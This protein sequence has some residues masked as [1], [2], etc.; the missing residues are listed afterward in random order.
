MIPLSSAYRGALVSSG[1]FQSDSLTIGVFS[2]FL[3]AQMKNPLVFWSCGKTQ[4]H[5]SICKLDSISS[6][7][8]GQNIVSQILSFQGA[9]TF[10]KLS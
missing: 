8:K 5:Q 1:T 9:G 6:L 2:H 10:S 4:M 7:G 3:N